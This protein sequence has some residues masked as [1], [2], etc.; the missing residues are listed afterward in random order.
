M[1]KNVPGEADSWALAAVDRTAK[2]L[3]RLLPEAQKSSSRKT[4]DPEI[5]SR[6]LLC[7]F[8]DRVAQNRGD[9]DGRFILA[10]GRGARLASTSSLSRSSFIIAV[11]VDAGEKGEGVVHL[12]SPLTEILI[13]QECAA[14]IQTLRQIGWDKRE[15]RI[16]AAVEERLGSVL[17]SA[18]PFIPSN[19]EAAPLSIR[20]Y[21]FWSSHAFF[22]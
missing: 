3:I 7:G 10:Q 22:Q 11:N 6:L 9:G 20:S 19:E 18:K 16:I 21:P 5:I 13:R 15:N 1:E 12:A 2:H 8:P 17:L 14:R 4:W